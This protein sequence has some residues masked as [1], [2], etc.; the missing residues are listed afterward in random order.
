MAALR[1]NTVQLWAGL[2][3]AE[4]RHFLRHLQPYWEVHRHLLPPQVG[5]TVQDELRAGRLELR[6]AR[7]VSAERW[8]HGARV[9]VRARGQ[10]QLQAIEVDQV[11]NWTGPLAD[12]ARSRSSLIRGLIESGC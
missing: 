2:P 3:L 1:M 11:I 7:I 9:T 4:R 12:P 6:A 5:R 10:S 8:N